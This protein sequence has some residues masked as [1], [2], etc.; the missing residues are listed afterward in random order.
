VYDTGGFVA[1]DDTNQRI[2]VSFR[3][4]R[5]AAQQLRN[6]EANNP[7]LPPLQPGLCG[8]SP[9]CLV[10]LYYSKLYAVR[11]ALIFNAVQEANRSKGYKV[12][13]TGHSLGGALGHLAAADLRNN[14]YTVD[15]VSTSLG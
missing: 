3:G 13:V 15:L 2:V 8:T 7:P 10:A 1:I 4:T 9:G 12:V 11:R 6:Q 5:N 14:G